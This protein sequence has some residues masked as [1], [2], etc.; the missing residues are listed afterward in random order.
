MCNLISIYTTYNIVNRSRHILAT[1]Y[2]TASW[3]VL[4]AD[5]KL[6]FVSGLFYPCFQPL[7]M[8]SF[9]Y[10]RRERYVIIS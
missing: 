4:G 6:T 9:I 2:D 8:S 1:P 3:L 7:N 5:M 10:C